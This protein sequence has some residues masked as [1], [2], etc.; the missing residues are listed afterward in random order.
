MKYPDIISKSISKR[1]VPEFI[2]YFLEFGYFTLETKPEDAMASY[3]LGRG[4]GGK[5]PAAPLT[6]EPKKMH[7]KGL[8]HRFCVIFSLFPFQFIIF[9]S[10]K[11]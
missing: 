7:I 11:S 9:S 8:L 6:L 1:K 10:S 5:T 4:G 2:I 3:P